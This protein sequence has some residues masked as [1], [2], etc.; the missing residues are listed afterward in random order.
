MTAFF[1]LVSYRKDFAKSH[2]VF[3]CLFFQLLTWPLA[4]R[5]ITK[6]QISKVLKTQRISCKG[7][8][9]TE[10]KF[11]KSFW[12]WKCCSESSHISRGPIYEKVLS[13]TPTVRKASVGTG[14]SLDIIIIQNSLLL[15]VTKVYNAW[16]SCVLMFFSVPLATEYS[17]WTLNIL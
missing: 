17:T 9:G 7:Y 14:I 12:L 5:F 1:S 13:N 6:A 3:V 10:E 4:I 11:C 16:L 15:E 8:A 2:C